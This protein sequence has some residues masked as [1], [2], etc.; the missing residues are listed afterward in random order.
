MTQAGK[1]S[2][3]LFAR[4]VAEGAS[5]MPGCFQLGR[6]HGIMQVEAFVDHDA[7]APV[8]DHAKGANYEHHRA[9]SHGSF[10]PL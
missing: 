5:S 10:S 1:S 9:S 4:A 8:Y 7:M 6:S 3:A 2:R